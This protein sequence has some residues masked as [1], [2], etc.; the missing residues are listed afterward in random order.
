MVLT[1]KYPGVRIEWLKARARAQ[2]WEEELRLLRE[3]MRRVLATFTWTASWWDSKVPY[4]VRDPAVTEGLRA[5]AIEHAD[6]YRELR[7]QFDS[8]WRDVLD[9]TNTFL[10]RETVLDGK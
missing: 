6:M 2:R 3:E 10:A 7:V 8:Q 1:N 9:R 4:S 5:Y